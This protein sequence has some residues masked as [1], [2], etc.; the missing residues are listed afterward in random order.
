MA[1]NYKGV[2]FDFNGTLFFDSKMHLEAWR[3]FSA[4]LRGTP[5]SDDEMR[6]HMFGRTN[7]D[8]ITYAIG[9]VPTP[10]IVEKYADEKESLYRDECRQMGDKCK[11]APFAIEFLNYLKEK[12]IKRTIATMSGKDNVDFFIEWFRL[13]N[14]FDTDRIVYDDGNIK[15]K[16][17]P[18]IYISAANKLGL[19]PQDCVVIE[20]A[21]SGIKSAASAGI[22][23]IVAIAS[24]E[25]TSLYKNISAVD[26]IIKDFRDFEGIIQR[27]S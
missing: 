4:K 3:K 16:P 14:W 21:I 10:E 5:F 23:K 13:E 11:L 26:M 6:E 19:N 20:D 8:I 18:D 27:N 7:L 22:G 25:D 15:G 1:D 12:N 24:M 9:K 2:I 17:E